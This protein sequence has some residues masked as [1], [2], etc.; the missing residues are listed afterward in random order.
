MARSRLANLSYAQLLEFTVNACESS[1]EIKNKADALIAEVAPLPSWCVDILL[2]PDL[3]PQ[4]FSSLGLSEHAAAGVCSTWSGAYSRQLRRRRYVNPRSERYLPD[5]PNHPNGLFMLPG[6]VLAIA[7][8]E[9]HSRSTVNFVA[10]RN[11]SDPQALAAYRASSLAA[12]RFEWL[13]GLA[14]TNDGL[15]ACSLDDASTALYKFAK[16][17]SMDELATVPVLADY[18]RGFKRCAVHQQ[19]QR[20]YALGNSKGGN[21]A[22]VLIDANLQV[23]ATVEAT[24][25]IPE[26]FDEDYD[27]D[28]EPIRD[29]AVHG[30]Q[31]IVLTTDHHSKG[32]GLRLL[33]L[34]GR[35]LRTIAA[36]QFHNPWV[37]TVSHGRAFVIDG[38]GI[39]K[40]LYIIDIQSGDILQRV[41]LE[42]R[43]C[44]SAILVD[45]DEIFI[46]GYKA[47]KVIVLRYAGSE[48]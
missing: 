32:S 11:D 37:V 14:H 47:S 48:A 2:S 41:R 40:D 36:A 38:D 4:L 43:G 42:L 25:G 39:G 23:F 44:V 9:A 27:E 18:D 26:G 22:L 13:M 24:G 5:V 7:T 12:R 28:Y 15:L 46:S 33:D 3:L 1:P 16:D 8:C 6:G 21:H 19:T 45:G 34:D 35:F 20:T 10:A 31:V 17:G 29:V 30:D